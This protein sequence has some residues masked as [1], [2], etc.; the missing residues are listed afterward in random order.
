MEQD[1]THSINGNLI[2][3]NLE[4]SEEHNNHNHTN[5]DTNHH[6]SDVTTHNTHNDGPSSVFPELLGGTLGDHNSFTIFNVKLFDL[7]LIIYDN[8]EGFHL[9]SGSDLIKTGTDAHS[10]EKITSDGLFKLTHHGIVRAKDSVFVRTDTVKSAEGEVIAIKEVYKNVPVTLDFSITNYVCFQWIAMFIILFIF[11]IAGR[12]YKKNPTKAPRGIQN[13]V[14]SVVLFIRDQ[15]VGPNIGGDHIRD[16]LIHYFL[17]L[18]FFIL[19]MNLLGLI[20]GGHTATGALGVTG[21]L[22]M[23]ALIIINITAIKEIGIKNWFKHL[24]GGAPVW[25]APIMVPIEIISMFTKPF[26]LT[27]RLFA[28]MTAG[29]VVLLSLVGLI[30]Y[31]AKLNVGAAVVLGGIAPISVAF[32]VFMTC[33]ELLVAFLQAYIFTILTAVF[34]GLAIGDHS[35]HTEGHHVKSH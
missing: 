27:I 1:S 12:R 33:L 8:K 34:T 15:V 35:N 14:E 29:H 23:T 20:P 26:A 17:A 31:F 22:A 10:H 32:S 2:V 25:L 21:A 28:N 13:V 5:Q 18:F 3:E 7:P 30:F 16:R 11:G 9:Y 24:L 6:P 19:T 4:Q